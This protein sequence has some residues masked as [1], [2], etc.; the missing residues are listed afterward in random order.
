MLLLGLRIIGFMANSKSK[1]AHRTAGK[2]VSRAGGGPKTPA[3]RAR[4]SANALTHG[5]TSPR[6]LDDDERARYQ[7][8]LSALQAHYPSTNPLVQMQ[9]KRIAR[10]EVQ[11]ERVQD[12]VDAS[13]VV[14][15]LAMD[16]FERASHALNLTQAEQSQMAGWLL[17]RFRTGEPTPILE[18]GLLAVATELATVDEFRLLTTHS[19]FAR[20]TPVF[21]DYIVEQANERDE[22]LAT[23]LS[24]RQLGASELPKTPPLRIQIVGS[25][26]ELPPEPRPELSDVSV[27]VL[28]LSAAWFRRQTWEFLRGYHR[29]RDAAALMESA[30]QAAVP[31]PEKLDRL[32]RYQTTLNRQLSCAIGE[33]LVLIK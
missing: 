14:E 33:L 8:F 21:C 27:E 16:D 28:Q 2:G 30:T 29:I 4:S 9:L 12:V 31:N 32:M 26:F 15:R 10:L 3:G 1:S 20:C 11:L 24:T 25:W 23:Y 18:P 22:S 5:A 6:L 13:F 7:T 19:D 17:H